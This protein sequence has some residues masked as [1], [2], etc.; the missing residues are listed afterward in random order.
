M[1]GLA[2]VRGGT[3]DIL[4]IFAKRPGRGHCSAFIADA[5]A[6]YERIRFL[7]VMNNHMARIL[8]KR[9]FVRGV[10]YEDGEMIATF[11]WK[12]P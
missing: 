7:H 12:R 3:L 9:G 1:Q 6:H 4:S 10:L 8:D 2:R 5:K 11:E